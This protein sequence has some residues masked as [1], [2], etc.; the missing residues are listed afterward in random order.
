M[1]IAR[2]SARASDLATLAECLTVLRAAEE[3]SCPNCWLEVLERQ[4]EWRLRVLATDGYRLFVRDVPV[5]G[6]MGCAVA[7]KIDTVDAIR[8]GSWIARRAPGRIVVV[9]L[10]T[11]GWTAAA[12]GAV[13]RALS[14]PYRHD[15]YR[16]LL[17]HA[18]PCHAVV[19]RWQLLELVGARPADPDQ[20]VRLTAAPPDRLEVAISAGGDYVP[21]GWATDVAWSG[22]A[23]GTV[24]VFRRR[25]VEQI[26]ELLPGERLRIGLEREAKPT[27]PSSWRVEG[28]ESA[29]VYQM[30]LHLRNIGAEGCNA[31]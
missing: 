1:D 25:D 14:P 16:S 21:I 6:V 28:D 10:S 17:E 20:R 5:S 9:T 30:Q 11:D 27:W 3:Q 12:G 24:A 8:F 31:R 26:L 15:W 13:F 18:Q 23:E 7:L 29:A 2:V 19:Q 22:E 4:Q